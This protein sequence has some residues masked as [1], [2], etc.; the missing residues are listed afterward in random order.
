MTLQIVPVR[1]RR[2]LARFID[3][4]WRIVAP[5]GY[6]GWIPPLRA[7]VADALDPKNP[8]YEDAERELWI[9]LRGGEP[10]GRIAAVHNRRHNEFHDDRVGFFGF[11]ESVDDPEVARALLDTAEGWLKPRGLDVM[12]GPMNPSTNHECGLLVDGYDTHTSFMS[13]WNP[14]YYE[15]LL[16]GAGM[17]KAKDLLAYLIRFDGSFALNERWQRMADRARERG[18]FTFREID[19]KHFQRDVELVWDIYNGAWEKNWGFVPMSRAEFDH[20]A[21][22]MKPLLVKEFVHFVEMGGQAVGVTLSIPDY[23]YA[24]KRV[25]SGR[26]LPAVARMLLSRTRIKAG[27]TLLLGVKREVRQHALYFALLDEGIKR[28]HR[29]GYESTEASWI[30]EDNDPMLDLGRQGGLSPNKRW[31]IYDRP[32]AGAAP[33][34]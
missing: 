23:N 24:M 10:V 8:F 12:R 22:Q 26:L 34:P 11:F 18:R 3:V 5:R 28:A 19:M 14:P 2:A 30:L 31:R 15:R 16:E 4:P 13:T 20:M 33:E 29:H 21:V 1:G 7:S 25:P 9:A 6:A 17:A 32:I 27:R